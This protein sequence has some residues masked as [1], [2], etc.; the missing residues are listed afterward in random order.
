MKSLFVALFRKVVQLPS[1]SRVTDFVTRTTVA[2]LHTVLHQKITMS[3]SHPNPQIRSRNLTFSTKEPDT[4]Q[5]IDGLDPSS[6]LWDIGANVGLYSVYAALN[7]HSVIAIE[8]SAFNIEFLVRNIEANDCNERISILPIAI[9]K[10]AR[11]FAKMILKS[12]AWGDSQNAFSTQMGQSGEQESFA[13]SYQTLGVELDALVPLL[14]ITKPDYLKL[15][16]DGIE[17]DIL[18]S[19]P[20]TLKTIS[21]VLVEVPTYP[22]AEQRIRDALTSAGLSFKSSHHRNQIWIRD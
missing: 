3:I 19:G 16:V 6:V 22:G 5:W 17:P 8:P 11:G 18:E 4:L 10:S 20:V 13:I 21:S 14:G 9:G 2:T 15:D 1:L 12:T 7:G